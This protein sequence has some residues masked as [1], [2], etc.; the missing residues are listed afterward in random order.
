MVGASC[1]SNKRCKT[2][3]KARKNEVPV[4][5]VATDHGVSSLVL[6]L[7]SFDLFSTPSLYRWNNE[8]GYIPTWPKRHTHSK[9]VSHPV[10]LSISCA[11]LLGSFGFFHCENWAKIDCRLEYG[12]YRL[13]LCF[14]AWRINRSCLVRQIKYATQ[15]FC[16]PSVLARSLQICFHTA[17]VFT[18]S[19]FQLDHCHCVLIKI[20][21]LRLN[22]PL[23]K[24]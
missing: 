22:S 3:R 24:Y 17:L 13:L 16:S 23:P 7:V 14:S 6:P 4:A 11:R 21:I 10:A 2:A 5:A 12:P 20:M 9:M 8:Y 1:S 18:V 15:T 19:Q